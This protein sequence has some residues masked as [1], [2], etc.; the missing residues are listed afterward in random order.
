MCMTWVTA[1]LQSALQR[2]EVSESYSTGDWSPCM[3]D[4]DG[5]V[6]MSMHRLVQLRSRSV[7]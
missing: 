5:Q 6:L 4:S 2:G 3:V 1:T 7:Q